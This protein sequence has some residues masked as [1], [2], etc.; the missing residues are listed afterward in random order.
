MKSRLYIITATVLGL[1]V[2]AY[3]FFR[4]LT[5]DS[6]TGIRLT[7]RM[8]ACIVLACLC[9]IAHNLCMTARYRMLTMRRLTWL[10][11]AKVDILCE[12]TSAITPSA[13]GGSGLIF[14][15]LHREGVSFSRSTMVMVSSLFLDELFLSV[16]CLGLMLFVPLGD[17]FG[18]SVIVSESVRLCFI[19]ALAG[20]TLW[21]AVL[22]IS[23]F[24]KPQIIGFL[25]R[26]ATRLPYVRRFE[27]KGREMAA[28][29]VTAS[30]ELRRNGKQFWLGPVITTI[31][32]W[33]LRY[34]VV[35][36]LLLAFTSADGIWLAYARQ[37]VLWIISLI[38]PT[39]GGSGL[40]EWMFKEYYSD[41]LPS[42]SATMLVAALWRLITYYTYLICG[43]I[44]VPGWLKG[45]KKGL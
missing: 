27:G 7:G 15:Y 17:L 13:V 16:S 38:S 24:W 44:V 14:L 25:V 9:F 4:D 45:L 35:M 36:F 21:T 5:P 20:I 37:W 29:M 31:G 8:V 11:A 42:T 2:V 22:G 6:F 32:S 41:F 43:A 18:S 39:P 10:Q 1:S 12:F 30:E 3:F 40:S 23:L 34:A 33:C 28:D 26:L 19:A